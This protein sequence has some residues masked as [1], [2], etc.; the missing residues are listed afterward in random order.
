MGDLLVDSS[1]LIEYFKGNRRAVKLME[2][3]EK[4][5]VVLHIN[6][7]VFNGIVYILLGHYPGN[8]PRTMKGNPDKLPP[9]IG[10]VFKV[11]GSFGFIPVEQSPFFKART[12][13]QK[14]AML[15]NDALTLANCI[16][17]GFSLATLDD[18][19]KLPPRRKAFQ[20]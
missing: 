14:Y 4:A 20:S 8:S 5:D 6:D 9:E 19:F 10:E 12:I 18:D 3:F 7:V 17:H 2:S 15:P 13:I 11:L 1:V 16:E